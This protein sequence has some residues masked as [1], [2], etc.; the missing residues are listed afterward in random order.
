MNNMITV[1]NLS[2]SYPNNQIFNN[3]SFDVS[4]CKWA[5]IIGLSGCGKTTFI[6]LINN[7]FKYD[8]EILF[9]GNIIII[10]GNF[11][12]ENILVSKLIKKYYSKNIYNKIINEYN[13]KSITSEKVSDLNEQ[14]KI[15][16]LFCLK[17][18]SKGD[19]VI[20]DNLLNKLNCHNKDIIVKILNKLKIKVINMTN[21]ME[22]TLL[23]ENIIIMDKGKIMLNDKKENIFMKYDDIKKIGLDLPFVVDLSIKLKYYGLVNKIYF[24]ME[25]LIGAIWIWNLKM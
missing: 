7:D 16:L 21:N 23:G 20:I 22:D 18:S 9:D 12:Y 3:L 4:M 15:K 5:T 2:F 10:D 11:N 6:R 8:G 14:D 19:I 25:E 13:L 24:S 1:K 17:L